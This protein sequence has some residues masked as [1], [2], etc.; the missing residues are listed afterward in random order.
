M[1]YMKYIEFPTLPLD[2]E[3]IINDYTVDRRGFDRVVKGLDNLFYDR[4]YI[5]PFD[6]YDLDDGE[7]EDEDPYNYLNEIYVDYEE[8]CTL[9]RGFSFLIFTFNMRY[10]SLYM[11]AYGDVDSNANICF[12][13]AKKL[14]S[15]KTK[16]KE[17]YL[18]Y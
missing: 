16:I 18:K 8:H 4:R 15:K 5:D 12:S 2:I 7:E 11:D 17:F 14:N 13:C 3:K 9:C 10:E 6:P 1:N